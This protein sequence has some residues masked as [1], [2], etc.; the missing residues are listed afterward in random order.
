MNNDAREWLEAN[1]PVSMCTQ[2]TEEEVVLQD[3]KPQLIKLSKCL[4]FLK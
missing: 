3:E 4:D 1:C 2:L